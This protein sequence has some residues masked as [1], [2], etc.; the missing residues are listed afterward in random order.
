MDKRMERMGEENVGKLLLSFSIPAII[1]MVVNAMYTVIDRI[2]VGRGV[3]AL[4][5]TGVTMTFPYMMVVLAIAMLIGIGATTLVS[6]KLGE[7]KKEDAEQI[8]FNA[9]IMSVVAAIILNVAGYIFLDQ[10]LLAFGAEGRVLGYAKEFMIIMFIASV[11][12]II[13]FVMNSIMRGSGNA[14][15]AM[16]T[17]LVGAI[18]NIILNPIFIFVLHLG[19]KGSALATLISMFVSCVWIFACFL[20]KRSILKL[21]FKNMKINFELMQKIAI[22]GIG[23]FIM[24]MT[25]GLILLIFNIQLKKYGGDYAVAAMGIMN[26]I[27]M[28]FAMPIFGINQ[29]VQPIIGYNFGA[30]KPAR[31]LEA[32]KLG[33]M[34]ATIICCIGFVFVMGFSEQIIKTFSGNIPELLAIGKNGIIIFT[35]TF[36]IIGFQIVGAGYFQAVGKVKHATILSMLRQFILLI[37]FLI[38]LPLFFGLNGVW[39]AGPSSDIGAGL[40]TGIVLW[41]ELKKIKNDVK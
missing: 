22:T 14:K 31:I 3:D 33:M 12:Q 29:A 13:A 21:R 7:R 4:A 37:P 26:S 25:G 28:L 36:P 39:A 24:Q 5:L 20:G 19:I 11:F 35:L 41:R 9:F 27:V 34:A 38:I 30:K 6:I 2:F 18:L 16:I 15:T 10:M 23:P 1:G 32:L 40:V 17:M 8:V